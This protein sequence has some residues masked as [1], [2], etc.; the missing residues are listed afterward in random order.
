[1]RYN[2]MIKMIIK[3]LV[4]I[5]AI[6]WGLIGFAD[7]NL[8][9]AVIP[10]EN[11]RKGIYALVGIAGLVLGIMMIRWYKCFGKCKHKMLFSE[12]ILPAR[13]ISGS[14]LYGA[15]VKEMKVNTVPNRK[16]IYWAALEDEDADPSTTVD[17]VKAYGDGTN[18][19][20]TM[21][22]AT[23]SA[24]LKYTFPQGYQVPGKELK[25]H[26]HYRVVEGPMSLGPIMTINL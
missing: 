25:P 10:N 15:G 3:L 8:V 23:G 20:V 4:I 19:G 9:E 22:D 13:F 5:G 12:S 1:M 17:Y 2:K 26:L 7:Y 6:N 18:S 24:T 21:S 14:E 16:I 11:L